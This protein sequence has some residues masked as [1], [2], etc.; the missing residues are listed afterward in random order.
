MMRQDV[1]RPPVQP[2]EDQI[3]WPLWYIDPPF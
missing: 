1:L 2:A 3:D